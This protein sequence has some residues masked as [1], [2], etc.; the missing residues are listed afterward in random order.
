MRTLLYFSAPWCG[1][2]KMFGPVM[3]NIANKNIPVTKVNVDYE[4]ATVEKYGVSS[5]PTTIL[6]EGDQEVRRFVGV[7]SEQQVID[8]YNE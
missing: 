1:P 2:C 7:K 3:D 8:F 4:I 5:V 6:V